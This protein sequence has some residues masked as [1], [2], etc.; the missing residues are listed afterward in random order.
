MGSDGG[1][2]GGS[3]GVGIIGR[4]PSRLPGPQRDLQRAVY[5][6][7][8]SA[9]TPPADPARSTFSVAKGCGPDTEERRMLHGRSAKGLLV[10][11]VALAAAAPAAWAAGDVVKTTLSITPKHAKVKDAKKGKAVGL[12]YDVKITRADG[13]RPD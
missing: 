13:S 10:A 9:K 2:T 3:P 1:H 11:G 7:P 12:K 4:T 6:P 8:A 5:R